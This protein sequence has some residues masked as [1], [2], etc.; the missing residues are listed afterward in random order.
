MNYSEP[1]DLQQAVITKVKT[2]GLDYNWIWI[3]SD[4]FTL[5]IGLVLRQPYAHQE[6]TSIIG[7]Y[8][9]V[10]TQT[11]VALGIHKTYVWKMLIIPVVLHCVFLQ[12]TWLC[13]N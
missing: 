10:L 5:C 3:Q 11:M 1:Q 8:T 13:G 6:D 7:T 9:E 12:T 4:V 2:I